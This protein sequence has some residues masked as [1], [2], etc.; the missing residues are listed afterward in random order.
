MGHGVG[1]LW[2]MLTLIAAAPA[3]GQDDAYDFWLSVP[4]MQEL[5]QRNTIQFRMTLFM[6]ARTGKVHTLA[7]DCEM[8]IATRPMGS[9]VWPAGIVVEPPNLCKERAP[10]MPSSSEKHLREV[11]WPQLLDANVMNATDPLAGHRDVQDWEA[12]VARPLRAFTA[13]NLRS[14]SPC[15]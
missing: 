1:R 11:L 13:R 15:T 5:A 8:H 4:V 9:P 14:P 7:D 6:E 3:A 10:G 2:L 12:T